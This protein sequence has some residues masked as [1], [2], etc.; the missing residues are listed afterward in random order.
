MK[1]TQKKNR[2][3]TCNKEFDIK[4]ETNPFCSN[5]CSFIDLNKRLSE[6]YNIQVKTID[7]DKDL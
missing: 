3:I 2:C 1:Q 6:K 4:L 5:R 7:Y